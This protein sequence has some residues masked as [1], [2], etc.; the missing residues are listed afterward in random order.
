[1]KFSTWNLVSLYRDSMLMTV[2]KKLSKYKLGVVGG[3]EVRLD[4]VAPNERA[5]IYIYIY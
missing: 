5:N 1:M 2:V 3:W 4:K